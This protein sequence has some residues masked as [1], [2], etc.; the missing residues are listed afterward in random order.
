METNGDNVILISTP[1][2]QCDYIPEGE[3]FQAEP[4]C[5]EPLTLQ[6]KG[7]VMQT[8]PEITSLPNSEGTNSTDVI[9]LANGQ[10]NFL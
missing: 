2:T 8:N 9:D 4:C 5:D 7:S 1:A 3:T 6:Y 10:I